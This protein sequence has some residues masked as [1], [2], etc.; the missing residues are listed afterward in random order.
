[1]R[2]LDRDRNIEERRERLAALSLREGETRQGCSS[3]VVFVIK[4]Q[5]YCV[6][7]ETVTLQCHGVGAELNKALAESQGEELS[8]SFD[9]KATVES[10]CL[11]VGREEGC[12]W[13]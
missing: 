11:S 8:L 13:V 2:K 1:M 4:F 3:K 9:L 12:V 5:F 7:F 10:G 6:L